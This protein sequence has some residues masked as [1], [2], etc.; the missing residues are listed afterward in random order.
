MK[1]IAKLFMVLCFCLSSGAK[2]QT[3]DWTCDI[4][5]FQYDMTL[6]ATVG[7][8]GLGVTNLDNYE[9]AAFCGNEC[10]GIG[11]VLTVEN[12]GI[13]KKYAYLRIR[14]NKLSGEVITFKVYSKTSS[15]V[16]DIK[17]V[18]INFQKEGVVGLPS[19][20]LVLLLSNLPGDVNNDGLV[21]IVDVTCVISYI[22]GTT[23]VPF[24]TETAD[25]NGDGRIDKIDLDNLVNIILARQ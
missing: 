15:E 11:T 16:I 24:N 9:I 18:E 19:N 2:A 12:A 23:P 6:Y 22:T 10:R 17:N 8:D 7:G 4:Y 3:P 25:L 21:D 5:A 20:P 13:Q 14:S 1:T